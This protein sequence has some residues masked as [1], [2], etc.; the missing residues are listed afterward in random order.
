M[1]NL[2][3]QNHAFF[4]EIAL[5]EAFLAFQ[6][7]E[8]PV[9]AVITWN[10]KVIAKARNMCEKLCDS[11]AHAEMQALTSASAKLGSKYLSECT[12]YVTLEPCPMCAG[13]IFWA[14]VGQL[15]YATS[16]PKRGFARYEPSLLHPK[17][18][19]ESG[20][21]ETEASLL[22]KDFFKKLR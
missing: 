12:L 10:G 3:A 8:I 7:G 19:V 18:K 14:Q 20:L 17:T 9:G 13:G 15:I 5:K 1:H 21:L 4:M 22:L 16:D 6:E 11:T 2:L